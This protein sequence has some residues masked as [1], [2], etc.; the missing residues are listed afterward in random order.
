M[1]TLRGGKKQA[2][3]EEMILPFNAALLR[4]RVRQCASPPK[5]CGT[6]HPAIA[7]VVMEW[8]NRGGNAARSRLTCKW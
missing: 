3:A 1:E 7:Q 8:L 5:F 2:S 4:R 6:A